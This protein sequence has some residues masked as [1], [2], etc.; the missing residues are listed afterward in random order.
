MLVLNGDADVVLLAPAGD[1]DVD[2]GGVLINSCKAALDVVV[3]VGFEGSEECAVV[4]DDA[5]FRASLLGCWEFVVGGRTCATVVLSMLTWLSWSACIEVRNIIAKHARDATTRAVLMMHGHPL[6]FFWSAMPLLGFVC[7]SWHTWRRQCSHPP[8]FTM[9]P[10]YV[11]DLSS[12]SENHSLAGV[13]VKFAQSDPD[14]PEAVVVVVEREWE[15]K[16]GLEIL[17]F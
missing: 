9:T 7:S 2:V 4:L 1:A 11:P 16:G 3:F 5:C 8:W 14:V 12:S 6:S 13:V 17:H 10:G 15:K